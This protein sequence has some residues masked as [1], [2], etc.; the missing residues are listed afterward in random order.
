MSKL[1]IL[2]DNDLLSA[3]LSALPS[4]IFIASVTGQYLDILGGS[5]QERFH[6]GK[7]FIGKHLSDFFDEE[8]AAEFL[9]QN[10]QAV[11]K[12]DV[13]HYVYMIPFDRLPVFADKEVPRGDRWYEANIA[14]IR[15]DGKPT[16][17]V[18]WSITDI[19][20]RK[21]AID[22]LQKQKKTLVLQATTDDLTQL[23]NRRRFIIYAEDE[24]Q[25]VER[26]NISNLSIL[27]LDIDHFKVINDTYGHA[28]GDVVLTSL[29]DCLQSRQRTSDRVARI[30]G[31]EFV[32]LLPETSYQNALATAEQ[33]R[34]KVENLPVSVEGIESPIHFTVSI[35][36]SHYVMGEGC[37]ENMLTR[38]DEGLYSAK[39]GGRNRVC[40]RLSENQSDR[41]P[42]NP[43]NQP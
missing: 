17:M 33:I 37:V 40:G 34:Q 41:I 8:M 28:A 5:D 7:Y 36:V 29:A 16:D 20:E 6:V 11:E 22:Q 4:P 24:I 10:R 23:L 35:G 21:L 32:V 39:N 30:G 27:M 14:P 25:R 38:A 3:V 19:T 18:V 9:A 15:K 13:V 1:S 2:D 42:T 26:Y 31:E 43:E 12:N